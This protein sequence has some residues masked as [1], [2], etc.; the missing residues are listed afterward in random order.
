M[1]I[2][3]T[4]R[5]GEQAYGVYFNPRVRAAIARR[6]LALGVEEM[7]LGWAGMEGLKELWDTARPL[8]G[9]T[10]L[11]LWA[12]LKEEDVEQ[13][14]RIRPGGLS[15]GVPA[16]DLHIEKRLGL[17][18]AGL[19]DRMAKVVFLARERNIPYLSLGFEDATRADT[20]FLL[21]LARLAQD[22]GA[23]R[24]RVA[25]SLGVADPAGMARLVRKVKKAAPG[26]SVAVHCHNDFGM[27][28]ANSLASLD[29]GAEYADA[30]VGGLGE[31]AGIAAL[32]ELA[33]F[34]VFRRSASYDLSGA[35][36]LCHVT[37]RAAGRPVPAGKAVSG[38]GIFACESGLHVVADQISPGIFEPYPPSALGAERVASVGM[39][40]GRSAVFRAAGRLGLSVGEGQA[41]ALTAAVRR[42]S[43]D[44][45]RP[46]TGREL[47]GLVK[48]RAA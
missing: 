43:K 45:G 23:D 33:A 11:S 31:R 15:L 34:L 6:I 48:G 22:L 39:K 10:R 18:R 40:S 36:A 2:D 20:R 16:S 44:L 3:T 37:A 4:L 8:A 13:A 38:D 21:D 46:L 42:A 32:E 25:D 19:A 29:A 7:E 5:E 26:V 30:S 24:I 41:G 17:G 27:A 9:T 14:A 28:T 1:L 47:A 35:R 12:R